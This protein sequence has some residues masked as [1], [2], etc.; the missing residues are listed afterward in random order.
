MNEHDTGSE[1]HH[2]P[3]VCI[4][5]SARSVTQAACAPHAR[6][7]GLPQQHHHRS[8]FRASDAATHAEYT[9]HVQ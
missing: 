5:W 9:P 7:P 4:V 1:K 3:K 2:R 8:A 6:W